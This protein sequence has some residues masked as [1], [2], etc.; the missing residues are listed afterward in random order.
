MNLRRRIFPLAGW[1]ALFFA[2][3]AALALTAVTPVHAADWP[4]WRYDAYRSAASPEVLAPQLFRQWTR[5]YAPRV[6]VW[7]DPLNHDLMPYDKVFEPVVLG[8]RMFIGFNDTDKVVALD[9]RSG[10]ELW[11]FYTDGPVRFAP[12]AWQDKLYF[13]SDDGYL[14]C[15]SVADGKL[16]WKFRGGP[17]DRKV[18]GNQRVISAWPARGGPVVRDARVYFAASIWPFMG[19]FIYALDAASGKVIWVN[20]GTGAQFIRQPHSAPSFGGVAPQ[21]ALVATQDILLV[22]GG[23]SVPAAF[24]RKTGEFIHFQHSNVGKGNG[25]SFVAATDNE[26]FLHTRVHGTRA[27]ELKTGNMIKLTNSEPVLDGKVWYSAATNKTGRIIQAI[28]T[29]KKVQWEVK[30]DATVDL[31]KAGKRL[32]AAGSNSVAAIELPA[33][34][35]RAR[36]A[37]NAP[38]RDVQRLLAANGKLIATTL[39]GRIVTFGE[40]KLKAVT[41]PSKPRPVRPTAALVAQAKAMIAEA[42]AGEGYALW[43][44]VEDG[45]LL[46]AVLLNSK[47]RIVAVDPDAEKVEQLRRRW[48]A[49]G[50]YGARVTLH[51]GD[52][53]SFKAPPYLANLIVVGEA[54]L[55]HLR[56][57]AVLKTVYD[58]L[59]PFGGALWL[60]VAGTAQTELARFLHDARLE[61]AQVNEAEGHLLVRRVGALPESANWT[62]QY[63]DIGNTLKSDDAR[64]KAP[65][66]L[67]WFGGTSN[68][69]V[70]PRHGHGPPEQVIGGRMFIQ[71][72]NSLSARDVYTG[73]LLWKS[74]FPSLGTF[75][76]YYDSS[77][78]NKPLS[79]EYNQKHIPGANG[80]GANYVATEDAVYLVITNTCQVLDA[81]TGALTRTLTL[82][83]RPGTNAPNDWAYIGIYENVLLAGDGF[84]RHSVKLGGAS[85]PSGIEDFSASDGLVAFD[86]HSGAVLWRVAARHSFLHNGIVAGNGRVYCLD[87]LPLSAE[88]KLKRRGVPIPQN[89]RLAA[90]DAQTGAPLWETGQNIFGTWLGYSKLHDALLLAGA[91]ATDRLKD[92]VGEGL[93]AYRG[94]DGEVRWQDL[95]RKYVGPVMLHN[96]LI[97]TSANSYQ[98]SSG[99]FNLHDGT[100]HLVRNPLTGKSEPWR[101]SRAYGCNNIVASEH[102]LTFRSGAAGFYDLIS[103]SGTGNLGGFKSGCTANLVVA[104]GVLNAPDYT[105]TCTCAYQNQT[106]LALIHMPDLELWTYS[107][108]GL[109]GESGERIE[110]VGINFGAPGDRRA[111]DGTLWLE[112][113]SVG[114]DSPGVPVNVSGKG[115][116]YF[117][118]H[119]SQVTGAGLPWVM[120][121]GVREVETITVTPELVRPNVSKPP[122]SKDDEEDEAVE[123]AKISG[124]FIGPPLP[125]TLADATGATPK[126]ELPPLKPLTLRPPHPAAPYTVRLYFA[127]PEDLKPGQRIF[128]I[129]LQGRPVLEKFDIALAAGGHHRGVV[130]EFNGIIIQKDLKLTLT[131]APGTKSGPIL[132][133]LELIAERR[134]AGN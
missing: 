96:D 130:K 1:A 61:Q 63:G 16:L 2:A 36:V 131:R 84:A 92:E 20:D 23:R 7:D 10:A 25:G 42:D 112:Y 68:L 70:L 64:V 18:L 75:G 98:S 17:S 67:L 72:M 21:G 102:L 19:T 40:E 85:K 43:F 66:G 97:L 37:W 29:D 12:V 123:R 5:Q 105:R 34:L 83:P 4:M 15:V 100:P 51:A 45:Q 103:K 57:G 87:K 114:G 133:G 52:P 115:V 69:D 26:Y 118:R 90:F 54:R 39:D 126:P 127:E 77:Y 121:S 129:A 88:D 128:S 86:R 95:K 101:I 33:G 125:P 124:S 78:T 9:L 28:G 116:A 56:T 134:T 47:L 109:D 3:V 59:R 106:S 110:R 41:L 99:A 13:T 111:A 49:A 108:F 113:P 82:P 24:D 53:V 71:G 60:P 58:S 120:A 122:R 38:V 104:N 55:A 81:R 93:T 89:Y 50:W 79:T 14:Y 27:F 73:R 35:R 76:I 46:E 6:Q 62:H 22:P 48:D 91:K 31:I 11:A 65:L 8:G 107:Q 94:L 80:R 117:R 74:E 32:Y 44:G 132:C 30:A 119:A